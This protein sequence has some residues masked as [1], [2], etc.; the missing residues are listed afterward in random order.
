MWTF[1]T[2]SHNLGDIVWYWT[3]HRISC[4]TRM[5][6]TTEDAEKLNFSGYGSSAKIASF[7]AVL[8]MSDGIATC[9]ASNNSRMI[10]VNAES[11]R[12]WWSSLLSMINL[13]TTCFDAASTSTIPSWL[14]Q[15]SLSL[16]VSAIS[17][18]CSLKLLHSGTGHPKYT[19]KEDN[20]MMVPLMISPKDMLIVLWRKCIITFNK[21][22]NLHLSK[23]HWCKN[24]HKTVLT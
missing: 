19:S 16:L 22:I 9:L 1:C 3:V 8:S 12:S 11:V 18:G 6:C 24:K 10:G 5:D 23:I 13:Q 14:S 21:N 2:D 7:S 17:R 15:N 20:P 4:S